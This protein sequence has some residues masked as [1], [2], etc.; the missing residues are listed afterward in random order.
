[1]GSGLYALRED[2]EVKTAVQDRYV[3]KAIPSKSGKTSRP[4]VVDTETGEEVWLLNRGQEYAAER[5]VR[6][7]NANIDKPHLQPGDRVVTYG[8]NGCRFGIV[9]RPEGREHLQPV[10]CRGDRGAAYISPI[11]FLFGEGPWSDSWVVDIERVDGEVDR[12][13][14]T[15]CVP[16]ESF[17][18]AW[19]VVD[20]ETGQVHGG[21]HYRDEPFSHERVEEIAREVGE[22]DGCSGQYMVVRGTEVA[23]SE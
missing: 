2:T 22:R 20:P 6:E 4:S 13:S 1:M 16:L 9:R 21:G 5:A 14:F 12:L 8:M 18:D 11:E 10:F 15:I 17:L 7:L 19:Y 23:I 3:V